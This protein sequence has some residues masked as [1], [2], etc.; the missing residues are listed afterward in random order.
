MRGEVRI[1]LVSK[2]RRAN[3]LSLKDVKLTLQVPFTG[4]GPPW[5]T[6]QADMHFSLP[7]S[8]P[9]EAIHYTLNELS[10]L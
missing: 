1:G 2:V 9:C 5:G 3:L 8:C 4:E 10:T 7:W 6:S